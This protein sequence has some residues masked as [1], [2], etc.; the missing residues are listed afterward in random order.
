V[1]LAEEMEETGFEEMPVFGAAGEE[2]A[3]PELAFDGFIDVND[4]EVAL[5]AGGDVETEAEFPFVFRDV[6]VETGGTAGRADGDEWAEFGS[7]KVD[8]LVFAFGF[9][10]RMERSEAFDDFV[11]FEVDADKIVIVAATLDG[12]PFDDVIGGSPGRVAHVRLGEN[13][14]GAGAGAAVFEKLFGGEGGSFDA[15]DDVEETELD[16]IG[17][18]DAEIQ[19]PGTGICISGIFDF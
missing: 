6:G 1:K 5:A 3:E 10:M 17:H 18:G 7:E 13:F 11:V 12:G 14:F 2:S 16:G 9:V 8:D 4:G 15:V 19:I